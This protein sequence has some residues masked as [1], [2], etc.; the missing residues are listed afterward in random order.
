M[1]KI[2]GKNLAVI[3]VASICAL[4][5]IWV[6]PNTIAL[7]HI[8]LVIGCLSAIGLIQTYWSELNG[9]KIQILP[10]LCIFGLFSWVLIH[11]FYFSLNPDLELSEIKGL[12]IRSFIGSIAA[13][14]LAIS[15]LK[16]PKLRTYFYIALF[17]TPAINI[18]SYFW[19]SFVNGGLLKPNDFIWFLFTKIETSYF[20]SVAGAIA[21]GNL[22][23]LLLQKNS[24]PKLL[25]IILWLSG[26]ILVLISALMSTT[27][28]GIS[29]AL[30]LCLLLTLV[31]VANIFF[32]GKKSK[33]TSGCFAVALL[34]VS[35]GVWESH[36]FQEHKAWEAIFQDAALGID[37][38][39]NLQWQKIEGSVELPRN[40]LGKPA[41]SS[42][43]TRFAYAAVGIRLIAKYPL[44]YGS[45]NRSFTGILDL[46]KIPHEHESQAH[47]GWIDFGLA[48]GVPGL[49]LIFATMISVIYLGLVSRSA[50]SL[51][52]VIFCLTFLP[53]GLIAEISWKQY[54]EATIFFLT[55]SSAVILWGC[56]KLKAPL[57]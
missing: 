7:R 31:V 45:I 51:P 4:L 37:I 40:S 33:V 27:K 16:F 13:I 43:Y 29:T 53:F 14:G 32:S 12:W 46:A 10:L 25:P 42:T 19:A 20:G 49:M 36:N 39:K 6:I 50:V 24:Q 5:F 1:L 57:K 3:S 28:N 26:L 41:V 22:I 48:F 56:D 8:L 23:V 54:F 55:L 15:I 35:Y 18:A 34:I 52:W 30:A 21:V 17:S 9:F 38:D 2:S 47:S 44:G 11:Y